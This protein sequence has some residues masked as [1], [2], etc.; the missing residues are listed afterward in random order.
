MSK[1]TKGY[2]LVLAA[3]ML[4][5][6]TFITFSFAN[7]KDESGIYYTHVNYH[8]KYILVSNEVGNKIIKKHFPAF[9]YLGKQEWVVKYAG[10]GDYTKFEGAGVD[11]KIITNSPFVKFILVLDGNIRI[12]GWI[13]NM[14]DFDVE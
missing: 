2:F 4:V 6:T 14:L 10:V 9:T 8:G 1:K 11:T 7:E 13:C 12:P 5:C 3:M